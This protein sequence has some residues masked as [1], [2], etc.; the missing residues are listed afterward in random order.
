[1]IFKARRMDKT[2]K[3]RMLRDKR[4]SRIWPL[5]LP[6]FIVQI[7]K[8]ERRT[9]GA[10]AE[11]EELRETSREEYFEKTFRITMSNATENLN[12]MSK[13]HRMRF[14]KVEVSDKN[15]FIVVLE[16]EAKGNE[17]ELDGW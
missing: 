5:Q 8:E 10:A 16:T 4:K 15:G 12:S 13:K 6:N 9:E 7:N 2:T 14:R 3:G 17:L 1:M 11:V